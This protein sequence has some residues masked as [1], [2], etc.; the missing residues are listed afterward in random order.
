MNFASK[1]SVLIHEATFANELAQDAKTKLHSTFQ[2]GIDL[3]IANGS[4]RTILTHFS[5][6]YFKYVP[7]SDEFTKNKILITHDFLSV[8]LSDMEWAYKYNQTFSDIMQL[9]EENKFEIFSA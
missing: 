6:R 8:K 1:S 3:G 5:P 2:E 9:I 4:W 7:H